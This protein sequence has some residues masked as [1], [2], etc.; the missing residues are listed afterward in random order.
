MSTVI[1]V[2]QWSHIGL[3][4]AVWSLILVLLKWQKFWLVDIWD[5]LILRLFE[6]TN[7]SKLNSGELSLVF[8]MPTL[9]QLLFYTHTRT[10]LTY[11]YW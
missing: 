3:A 1:I 7:Y 9:S 2:K 11:R 10:T 5:L 8:T 4:I 6:Y